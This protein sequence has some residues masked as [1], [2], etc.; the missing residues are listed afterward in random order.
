MAVIKPFKGTYYNSKKIKIENVI[1]QPYDKIDA[2]LYQSYLTRDPCNAVRLILKEVPSSHASKVAA[3]Y[4]TQGK[5]LQE[6]VKSGVFVQN[7]ESAI[8]CYDQ[9]F[10]VFGQRKK[11][12]AFIALGLLQKYGEGEVYPHEET[13]S[14]PK[15]D[16]LNHLRATQTHFGLI[17]MLYEDRKKE[18]MELLN[19]KRPT[20]AMFNF[21]DKDYKVDHRLWAIHDKEVLPQLQALMKSKKLLIADGHHRYETALNF[22]EEMAKRIQ[23]VKGIN[24]PD[25]SYLR[26]GI[27]GINSP[28]P[29]Y[30]RGGIDGSQPFDYAMM[31]F[32][33]L[34]DE[35]LV[36]LPT[37]RLVRN[38]SDEKM[39]NL[40]EL[41]KK[42]FHPKRLK[43][44]K[45]HR[46]EF[47]REKMK[48]EDPEGHTLGLY[49]GSDEFVLLHYPKSSVPQDF[50]KEKHSQGWRGLDVVV[51][52][53]L[54]LEKVLGI[55]PEAV[56]N[57]TCV[58]YCREI[59]EALEAVHR[60]GSQLAFFLNPTQPLQVK[61]V[62]FG[63]ER[64]PQKS[65]DFYPK[66]MTGLMMNRMEF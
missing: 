52:H 32:V 18:V 16:R 33:N 25:P 65:T 63:Q 4:E 35:G 11:R 47:I 28:D 51:L 15:A 66:L 34:Y 21:T 26:G 54:I 62:A 9:E 3:T 30:L 45:D 49:Y 53:H 5:L 20:Q 22:R 58:S 10:T 64:M 8:Y 7:Q 50:F 14:K 42:D 24:S 38:V 46:S 39:M 13:L 31:A 37:H 27:D 57:E 48:G 1:T 43:L 19:S 29:S 44:P 23:G 2:K 55:D 59:G 36:I 56:R 41:L 40:Q 61:D 60:G 12:Q 17:F 6:W